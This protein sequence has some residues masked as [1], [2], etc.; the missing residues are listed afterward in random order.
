[1]EK[2]TH[3]LTFWLNYKSRHC[4]SSANLS[5]LALWL[6]NSNLFLNTDALTSKSVEMRL[7]FCVWVDMANQ[8]GLKGGGEVKYAD[9][10]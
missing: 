4:F 7:Y 3:S 6:K 2:F 9:K 10:P 8:Q 1:M 5:A